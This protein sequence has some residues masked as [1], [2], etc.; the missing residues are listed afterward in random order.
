M[1]DSITV[2]QRIVR[3]ISIDSGQPYAEASGR[4]PVIADRPGRPER[5][6]IVGGGFAGFH[7]A[8]T[9]SRTVNR[10]RWLRRAG[11]DQVEIV[12]ISPTDY[13]LYLPL[14]P[15]VAAGILDPRRVA[16]PLADAGPGVR[17]VPGTVDEVDIAAR[18]VGF[19]D[20][21]GIQRTMS[22]DRLL[23]TVGSV[24]KLLPVPGLTEH[25]IGF[26]SIREGLALR[27]HL[28]RQIELA[29]AAGVAP[30]ASSSG[31]DGAPDQ[32]GL[33]GQAIPYGAPSWPGPADPSRP[34]GA[35]G[36]FAAAEQ[37]AR[38]TFVV[39]GAGY[40]GTEVAA[41]G[42][43]LTRA[44]ARNYPAL[45]HQQI[46]WLLLETAP[47]VLPEL[48]RHLSATAHRVLT[49]RGVEIRTGT[50][51]EKAADDGVLTSD[52]EFVPTRSLIWCVGV[53]PDPLVGTLGLATS[54]GRLS[55]D[56]YLGVPGHPEIFACGDAAAVPD[57]TRPGEITAMTA[58][59][60]VRQG[61]RV[62]GNIAASL[63][64]GRRRPYRHHDLG[65]TVD[66]GGAKAAAN[67]AGLRLSG[68]PA[69]AVTRGY[70]LSAIP[71][72]KIRIA[73]DWL[74]DAVLPRQA[75]QLGL[76]EEPPRVPSELQHPQPH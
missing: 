74:L 51:I 68:V 72:N 37:D 19:T 17:T 29:A 54:A 69:K 33:Q 71:A 76:L 75:V 28:V 46:R 41:H 7:A 73:S 26:R 40:T 43:L 62:A 55:V 10:R 57:L 38:C 61:R 1:S 20:P 39:V 56:E 58:Q 36:R 45:R 63:G 64:Y 31:P 18:S 49:G 42:Q 6:V 5:I 12:L 14:L 25:A 8:R 24:G 50:T 52:G 11:T 65:F 30:A 34:D 48:D 13:F 23:L 2:R 21:E 66:L 22:Y 59:H 27:D 53:R 60:A 3:D 35:P 4:V 16:V 67:P 32:A 47:R 15:E 9:L 70:H 44:V